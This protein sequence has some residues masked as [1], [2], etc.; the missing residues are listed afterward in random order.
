VDDAPVSTFEI[1]SELV[2]FPPPQ[3]DNSITAEVVTV[4]AASVIGTRM[5]N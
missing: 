4:M 5:V 1:L 2:E 3:A